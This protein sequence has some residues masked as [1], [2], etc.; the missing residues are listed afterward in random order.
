MRRFGSASVTATGAVA[1]TLAFAVALTWA[2]LLASPRWAATAAGYLGADASTIRTAMAMAHVAVLAVG[3]YLLLRRILRDAEATR[4]GWEELASATA[5]GLLLVEVGDTPRVLFINRGLERITDRSAAAF[6]ADPYL[7][8][9]IVTAR[10]RPLLEAIF[11][12]PD[13]Q[14]WPVELT[15]LRPDGSRRYVELTGSLVRH[16]RNHTL[17]QGMVTDVTEREVRERALAGVADSERAAAQRLRE[18]ATMRDSFVASIS[19]EL[20]TPLTVITGAAD[21]LRRHPGDLPGGTRARLEQAI[22]EQ[23]AKLASLLDDV[24][25]LGDTEYLD[26]DHRPPHQITDIGH[27]ISE[28]VAR[29]G[30]ADRVTTAV[31]SPVLARADEPQLQRMVAELLANAEKYA[32]GSPVALSLENGGPSWTLRIRDQGPGLSAEHLDHVLK[33]FY[34]ADTEHPQ[35]GLGLGLT[36]VAAVAAQHGG[37]VQLT[38][39]GGLLVS[40]TAPCDAAQPAVAGDGITIVHDLDTPHG[41]C[42]GSSGSSGTSGT[43]GSSGEGSRDGSRNVRA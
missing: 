36:L 11:E 28:V 17:F 41:R 16:G 27:I 23:S 3:L 18:I 42:P 4:H 6:L 5:D 19:H 40:I 32:P 38:N 33:P 21:T 7:P 30:I 37:T 13:H 43:S 34:R 20:R 2:F 25:S 15:V 14:A 9:K 35:P 8:L 10:D 22:A 1:L 24:L 12:Q 26:R 31:S 39:D 29:S